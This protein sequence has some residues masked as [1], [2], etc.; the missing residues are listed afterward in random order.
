MPRKKKFIETYLFL[1]DTMLCESTFI[2][3]TPKDMFPSA[4]R[5]ISDDTQCHRREINMFVGPLLILWDCV[6]Q[7]FY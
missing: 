4:V 6:L 2:S 1:N 5:L 3:Q 7:L